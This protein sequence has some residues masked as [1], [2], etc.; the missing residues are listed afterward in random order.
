MVN[1]RSAKENKTKVSAEEGKTEPA[2]EIGPETPDQSVDEV[3][4][5]TTESTPMPYAE[6]QKQKTVKFSPIDTLEDTTANTPE[7]I[8]DESQTK[9]R[10]SQ[11]GSQ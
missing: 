8:K 9:K 5:K 11:R 7:T 10:H 4:K 3:K 2:I 1:T 6:E